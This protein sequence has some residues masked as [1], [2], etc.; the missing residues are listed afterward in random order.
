MS[1]EEG[2]GQRR[3]GAKQSSMDVLKDED[4]RV[5]DH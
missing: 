5:V 4:P 3:R 2:T 1:E